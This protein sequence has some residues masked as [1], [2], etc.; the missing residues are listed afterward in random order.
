MLYVKQVRSEVGIFF[1][2]AKTTYSSLNQHNILFLQP[3]KLGYAS[4]VKHQ[5]QTGYPDLKCENMITKNIQWYC[6]EE[7]DGRQ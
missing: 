2:T 5:F 3:N 6:L 4:S 1:G 7:G